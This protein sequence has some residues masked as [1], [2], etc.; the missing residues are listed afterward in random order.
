M[1]PPPMGIMSI[2]VSRKA[3]GGFSA[4]APVGDSGASA[5]NAAATRMALCFDIMMIP[6]TDWD[7]MCGAAGTGMASPPRRGRHQWRS[8][9]RRVVAISAHCILAEDDA[10]IGPTFAAAGCY[11]AAPSSRNSRR[12]HGYLALGS[13]KYR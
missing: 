11:P 9:A 7:R 3:N 10:L 13:N 6:S 2:I 8:E 1:V 4:A 5:A 12:R